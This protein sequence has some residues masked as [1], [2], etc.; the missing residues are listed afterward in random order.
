LLEKL[1]T[2]HGATGRHAS[3]IDAL[4]LGSSTAVEGEIA[5]KEVVLLDEKKKNRVIFEI[6][7]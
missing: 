4:I 7:G 2:G 1:F 3:S 5:T 6:D